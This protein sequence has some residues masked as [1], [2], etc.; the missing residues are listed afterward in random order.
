[1]PKRFKEKN[2]SIFIKFLPE[3]TAKEV[4]SLL[5]SMGV[6]GTRVSTLI[7]RWAID[8]PFWKEEFFLDK[9]SKN[10][11]VE[12]VHENYDRRRPRSTESENED[13]DSQ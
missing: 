3:I 11:L 2:K 6:S 4:Q 10:D 9:F 8:I 5:G 1:M 7:N 12:F 13:N